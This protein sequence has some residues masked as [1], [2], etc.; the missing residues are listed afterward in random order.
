[1]AR[2]PKAA[3]RGTGVPTGEAAG[4]DDAAEED[5]A[6]GE[7]L[8]FG[9]GE[10]LERGPGPPQPAMSTATASNDME[11][12]TPE[13]SFSTPLCACGYVSGTILHLKQGRTLTPRAPLER[14]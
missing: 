6:I 12:F 14:V 7:A 11:I 5:E 2:T 1:M 3:V 8:A 9:L 13:S 4:D 10:A